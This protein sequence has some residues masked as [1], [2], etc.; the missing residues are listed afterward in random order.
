MLKLIISVHAHRRSFQGRPFSQADPILTL[1]LNTNNVNPQYFVMA[2][3]L[4]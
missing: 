1:K 4:P 3:V 2:I